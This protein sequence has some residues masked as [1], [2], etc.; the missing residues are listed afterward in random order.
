MTT[1]DRMIWRPVLFQFNIG[2]EE[3]L[4]SLYFSFL[5]FESSYLGIIDSNK[6]I[7]YAVSFK[8]NINMGFFL[9]VFSPR[10][11]NFL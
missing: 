5:I 7:D 8:T 3:M 1:Q 6:T 11:F 10:S 4:H 9:I 2:L